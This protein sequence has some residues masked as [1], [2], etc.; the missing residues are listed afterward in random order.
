MADKEYLLS[1]VS[2][3]LDIKQGLLSQWIARG[4]V[5]ASQPASGSGTRNI[6]SNEDICRI[7]LFIK[8]IAAGF[9]RSGAS[10][11]AFRKGYIQ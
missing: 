1:D 8:F 4:F 11:L 5:K 6:F 10:R 9:T 7:D 3:H 2:K